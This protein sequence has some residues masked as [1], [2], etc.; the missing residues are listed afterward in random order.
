LVSPGGFSAELAESLGAL[1][2]T[3]PPLRDR[4][5]DIPALLTH[6]LQKVAAQSGIA[7]PELAP[8]LLDAAMKLS[9]LGNFSQLHSAAE[10]LMRHVDKGLLH[11][12]D[13]ETVLGPDRCET[14]MIRLDEVIQEHI[15]TALSA[16]N[17]NKM[18]TPAR[19]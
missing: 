6:I 14:R 11:A 12:I 8:D 19:D 1:R 18:R 5:E 16:C 9:W 2:I 13:L 17:G 15:R 4:R 7:P 10:G 3:L